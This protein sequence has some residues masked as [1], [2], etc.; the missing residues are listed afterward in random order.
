MKLKGRPIDELSQLDIIGTASQIHSAAD[1]DRSLWDTPCSEQ[2]IR[3]DV[4]SSIRRNPTPTSRRTLLSTERW[5]TD[6]RSHQ[7]EAGN[8]C[9]ACR[10]TYKHR[11]SRPIYRDFKGCKMQTRYLPSSVFLIIS[12]NMHKQCLRAY[13]Y[14]SQF[15]TCVH[16]FNND[17]SHRFSSLSEN[18]HFSLGNITRINDVCILRPW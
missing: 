4:V 18:L 15:K 2:S 16:H 5:R 3:S 12:R 11:I 1:I 9:L 17:R 6:C 8:V 10:T 7:P 13:L 14:H